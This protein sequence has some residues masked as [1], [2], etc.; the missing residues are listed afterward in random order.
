MLRDL[1]LGTDG[2][3]LLDYFKKRTFPEANPRETAILIAQLGDEDFDVRERA[4]DRLLVLGA[5]A[6]VG[7]KEAEKNKDAEVNRRAGVLLPRN[8]A[9]VRAW[10]PSCRRSANCSTIPTLSCGSGSRWR[11]CPIRSATSCRCWST[12]WVTSAPS[13]YGR[14]KISWHGWPATAVRPYP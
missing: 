6:L 12:S 8:S 11:W 10:Q 7:I 1:G 13:S 3:A 2:P 9:P 5:G 4:Y 14:R